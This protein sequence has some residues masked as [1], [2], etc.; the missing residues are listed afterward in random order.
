VSEENEGAEPGPEG[1]G[2]DPVAVALALGAASRAQADVFLKR[3]GRVA[4]LLARKLEHEEAFEHSHLHWRRFSD[5][6]KGALQIM[7][8]LAGLGVVAAIGVMVWNAAHAGGTVVESFA[9]PPDLAAR[10]LT[11]EVVAGQLLDRLGVIETPPPNQASAGQTISASSADDVKVEIPETGISIGELYRFLRKWLGHET[12]VGGDVVRTAEG[13]AVTVRVN[14]KDGAAYAGPQAGLDA[15]IQ[16]AAEHVYD[17][18]T[19]WGYAAYLMNVKR[20]AEAQAVLERITSDPASDPHTKASAWNALGILYGEARGDFRTADLMYR[21][22]G[23]ADPSYPL[24]YTNLVGVEL[25]LGHAEAAFLLLPKA[26]NVLE[27]NHEGFTQRALAEIRARL[28]GQDAELYGD[29]AGATAEV[30]PVAAAGGGSR[31]YM[32]VLQAARDSAYQHDGGAGA[33]LAQQPMPRLTPRATVFRLGALFE[34]EAALEHW[35]AVAAMET[36]T[37]KAMAQAADGSDT[38][39]ESATLLHPRLA[40]AKAK[41]GDS[42]GAQAVIAAAPGDCYDCV[43]LHGVIAAQA[44]QW[45]RADWWFA[46]AL[47]QGPSLPFAETDWGQSLLMR[48]QPDAAITQFRRANQK[49]PHFADA[50]EGW[51][52][53]LMAQNRS[54]LALAKFEEANKYAP[55]WGRLHLK[56]GEALSYAGKPDDAKKQFAIAAGLDLTA[57]DKAELARATHG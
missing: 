9:V 23:E 29:Y 56:W 35:P 37:E 57:A 32:Y 44:R 21:R 1:V 51:G 4:E 39:L 53:A 8:V 31:Q 25:G 33:W 30:K 34:I 46:R 40:L 38:K 52:E 55:N 43:R 2:I 10:G 16:K 24:G 36:P 48:G 26:I 54:D 6:M 18:T 19:P 14:G 28:H 22:A 42:A 50:L 47:Q 20:A 7:G 17:V 11:G 5:R 49:G 12:M 45:G 13:L 15:L 27:H 41:T 3:Q